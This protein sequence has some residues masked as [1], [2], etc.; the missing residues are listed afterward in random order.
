MELLNTPKTGDEKSE[1][2]G[3]Q[4][5]LWKASGLTQPQFCKQHELTLSTFTYWRSRIYRQTR[6]KQN[7]QLLPLK[8]PTAQ[9]THAAYLRIR[10]LTGIVVEVPAMLPS[11]QIQS[12]FK[13][14]GIDE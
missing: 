7:K 14:L 8:L 5:D 10:L 4:V 3:K 6:A 11:V 12:I 2:W 1:Y 13:N 9:A